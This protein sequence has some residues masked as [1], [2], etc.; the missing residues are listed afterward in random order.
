MNLL[1]LSLLLTGIFATPARHMEEPPW[2]ELPS[3]PR[4][5]ALRKQV[6]TG[7]KSATAKFWEEMKVRGAP[8]VERIPD[9]K[10]HVLV[11]FVYRAE[12]PTKGVVLMAQ[13]YVHDDRN[14][15]LRTLTHLADTD[16][17]YKTYWIRS[18]M[19]FTYSLVPNPTPQSLA[20]N[21]EQQLQDRL[22]PK[23]V[24]PGTNV[25]K[26]L[27]ELS[28]APEQPWI[29]PNPHVRSGKLEEVAIESKT[30]SARRRFWVYTPAG[31]DPKRQ[32]PYPMLICFDGWIY[33][34]PEFVP[35][36]TILDN[37]IANGRIPPVIAVFRSG[38]AAATQC[39]ANQQPVISRLC[40]ERVAGPGASQMA[41]HIGAI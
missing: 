22:N 14:D 10:R 34:R 32:S 31:Y 30:L 17:W 21:S 4:I 40:R 13:L 11:T 12:T 15:S 5:E 41:R 20:Y 6:E 19:R 33:S 25:G 1:V 3:S 29:A 38:A 7:D 39:R 9:D 24:P 26:S 18:D 35:T 8:L 27:V 36:P 2:R 37:L 16:V 23:A 28:A